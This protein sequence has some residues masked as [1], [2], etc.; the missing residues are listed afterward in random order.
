[1]IISVGGKLQTF[2]GGNAYHTLVGENL[3]IWYDL[4]CGIVRQRLHSVTGP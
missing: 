3:R 1:M 2:S 4:G